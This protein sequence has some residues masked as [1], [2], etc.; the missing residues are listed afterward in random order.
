MAPKNP[1]RESTRPRRTAPSLFA[2]LLMFSL[3]MV[4]LLVVRDYLARSSS[5]WIQADVT[6]ALT[7]LPLG[8]L[9]E[10]RAP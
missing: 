9:S 10:T 4:V 1:E 6:Q 8:S 3:V 2:I 5:S 7:D